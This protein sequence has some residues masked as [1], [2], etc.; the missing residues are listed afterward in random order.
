MTKWLSI[1]F[2]FFISAMR[3]RRSLAL[4]NLALRQQLAVLSQSSKRPPISDADRAF[5]AVL[6]KFWS[7]WRHALV[8]VKPETVIRW[9]REAFRRRWTRKC[10][11]RGRPPLDTAIKQLIRRLS[12]ANPLWGAPRIHGELLKLGVDVS[13]S[14]VSKCMIRDPKP[15]SQSWRTFL[16]NH[17]SEFLATDFFTVPT[18]TFKVLFVMVV[19]SHSRR[20]ILH[21]NVTE[22]PTEVWAARQVLEAMSIDNSRR[23][24]LRDRD[25]KCGEYFSRQVRN[26]G[27]NEVPTAPASP[28]QNAYAERLIGSMRRECFDH[29]I[30]FG[31][32]HCRKLAKQ[33]ANYYNLARTHL[34]LDKDAPVSRPAQPDELGE[35]LSRSHLAGLHH[36]YYRK[37]A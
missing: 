13:E 29:A 2:R 15:P 17:E 33:Y 14:V 31:E 23:Y 20:E 5:W 27:M 19:L 16:E 37:A 1:F 8:L 10:R 7:D 21:T 4:E 3:T 35:I 11:S 32:R 6:S 9:H 25:A 12:R 24:L 22:V 36:E 28:W 18:A 34:S 26:Y 30:V